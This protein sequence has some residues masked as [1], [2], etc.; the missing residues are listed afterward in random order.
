MVWLSATK[1]GPLKIKND[2]HGFN[3]HYQFLS[4]SYSA[5]LFF[6]DLCGA[7][8]RKKGFDTINHDVTFA[9]IV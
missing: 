4:W 2:I 8:R 9:V 5:A 1:A 6:T 3:S 7:V